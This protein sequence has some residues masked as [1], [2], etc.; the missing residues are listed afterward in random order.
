[1]ENTINDKMVQLIGYISLSVIT[2]MG[3]KFGLPVPEISHQERYILLERYVDV[4]CKVWE[5]KPFPIS[6]ATLH[7]YIIAKQLYEERQTVRELLKE[8]PYSEYDYDVIF[9][10]P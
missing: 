2:S 1:M 9:S 4:W 5:E 3:T 10:Q 6:D 8:D 7:L